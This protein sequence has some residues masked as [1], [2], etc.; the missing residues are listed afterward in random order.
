[1]SDLQILE[2]IVIQALKPFLFALSG[3]V[4]ALK[5]ALECGDQL[6]L[7]V[8]LRLKNR[9]L[10]HKN[11]VLRA[12]LAEQSLDVEQL[13]N[14]ADKIEQLKVHSALHSSIKIH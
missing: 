14:G 5:L 3:T 9:L 1:V 6:L 10:V 7:F 4:R 13:R 8:D 11:A 12:F 2:W